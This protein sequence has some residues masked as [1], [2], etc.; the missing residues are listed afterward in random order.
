MKINSGKTELYYLGQ[1]EGKAER[2]AQLLDCRVGTLPTTYLGFPLSPR[3]PTKEVWRG[4]IQ[5]LR[6]RI[7]GWQAK[8]LSR[9]G[10]LI[11]VNAVL[12][13]LPL[14]FLSVFKM[15]KWLGNGSSIDFW[16][17]RWCGESALK[18]SFP[19]IYA[20]TNRKPLLVGDCFDSEDWR[21]DRILGDEFASTTGLAANLLALKNEIGIDR[22]G[23]GGD[24]VPKAIFR[25]NR[26]TAC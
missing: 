18:T 2:L 8:L 19:E 11:L 12:T 20:M 22:I 4:I 13:N 9:G 16:S 14:Y 1:V 24:G 25:S 21:W 10:R 23:Y 15:P 3:P 7:D 6:N 17:N 5:K 26:P